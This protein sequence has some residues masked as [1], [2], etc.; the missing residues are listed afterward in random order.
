MVMV[1]QVSLIAFVLIA[2]FWKENYGDRSFSALHHT[3]EVRSPLHHC[4][5][6]APASCPLRAHGC[7]EVAVKTSTARDTVIL[8]TTHV[9]SSSR[10]VVC[11]QTCRTITILAVS[12]SRLNSSW[13]QT[14]VNVTSVY[15][16]RPVVRSLVRLLVCPPVGSFA[17]QAL[18]RIAGDSRLLMMGL[19]QVLF[20]GSMMTWVILWVPA[21]QNASQ[22]CRPA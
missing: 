22:V 8:S 9:V 16:V 21:F 12:C 14:D 2:R 4:S 20:E 7:V 10:N 19:V 6:V 5:N 15:F 13:P 17:G 11:L 18:E 1:M 3:R